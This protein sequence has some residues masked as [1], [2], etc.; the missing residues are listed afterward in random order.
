MKYPFKSLLLAATVL[1]AA[2]C[3]KDDT[4]SGGEETAGPVIVN[5]SPAA[6]GG[7]IILK[8]KTE[9]SGIVEKSRA[10]GV[11][12][13]SGIDEIDRI[14]N[15]VNTV[16]FERLFP[17]GGRFE[18]RTRREG[19][20]L[21]YYAKYDPSVP[22]SEMASLLSSC[23][24]IEIIEYSLAAETSDHRRAASPAAGAQSVTR[25]IAD[26]VRN[27]PFPFNESER[28]QQMQWH[29]NNT[30]NIFAQT[31]QLGADANVYAAWQLST[32]NPDVIVA[33]VDQ[34]VKYDHEDLA[35]NMWTNT[36]ELNGSEGRDDDSN[37]YA[38]DIHG[39]N[40]VDNTTLTISTKGDAPDHGTHVA[41]TVAAVNN[42]GTGVAGIAG[43]SG[44]NDGVKIMSCQIF[45][46]PDK[47][48]YPTEDA[49]RYAADNGALICQCSYGYSYSTGSRD[50]ME[51]MRQWFMNS[52]EKAA[53]DYFIANAGKNDPDSP[54]EG[55]VV[56]FAAG[57][58]GNLFRDVSEYPA[59]YEAVVSV[60]AMG[61]DFLPAYYTCYNDGVDI[62]APGGDLYNSSLGTDNGGVLST[63]LS[64]PS[65]TYYDD[66]RRQ[67][68]TD[69]N[70]Y[71]YMQGTSMACPHVSGVAALGLSYLSQLGYRMT[72]D[73]YKKL[74]LESVH[75]IDSYLTGTK[76][77]D[78]GRQKILLDEYKGKMGAGYLDANLLLENIKVAFGEKTPPR[79]TARIANRLLKTDTPTSSVA[80]ADYFTDDAVS[81]Y[82][83]VAND[84]S[85][86][87][88]N[89]SDGVLRML[90]KK[91]G[92]VRVTVSAR[93][94]E[95]TVVSQS[96]YVTVRSQSNSADGWL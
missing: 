65:V 14:L 67:G 56:I 78:E 25:A 89:V 66:E 81:Q 44:K 55:G 42:N 34:G 11:S 62:T 46:D 12:K 96:F 37:G 57:N 1:A 38:D 21:W 40:F 72:A 95:G 18:E 3:A 29:Y 41:G 15:T 16:R 45:G 79:V 5:A 13:G 77:Y 48:S 58:D 43:G 61:S 73:A 75:P 83:A 53:I 50:E 51:A 26:E 87:R 9:A 4:Q 6:I 86:V 91:V 84:E 92:Q 94:F 63:I 17:D 10:Q 35:A 7:E 74:L 36:A 22:T 69:S 8:L 33:V 47:R 39:F 93:G 80:L 49:F 85:V 32:G 90:P 31:S 19:L 71:G 70:V 68:L 30:G 88:V 28:S 76:Y 64:D 20:H 24:D 2:S 59:S 23:K 52:S 82:D 27:V 54:I 60:A